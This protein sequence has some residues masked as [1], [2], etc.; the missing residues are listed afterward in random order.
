LSSEPSGDGPQIY[1]YQDSRN[2]QLLVHMDD[3]LVKAITS[4]GE[5]LVRYEYAEKL[6]TKIIYQDNTEKTFHYEN[7]QY[8]YHLT[9]ITNS[10]GVR[11]AT[12]S[13]DSE[14]R[15]ISS[16][17][18]EGV[19]RTDIDYSLSDNQPFPKVSFTNSLGKTTTYHYGNYNG[20]LKVKQVEGQS[21]QNCASANQAYT[22]DSNGFMA[23]KT[24]WKGNVTTYVHNDRGLETSR[25][26]ASGT[27]QARTTTTEWHTAFNLRIKITEPERET[28]LS[29]DENGRLTSQ[30]VNPR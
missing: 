5:E 20:R 30:E 12:W 1:R 10:N 18:A 28:V 25:T 14:G 17:H 15:A 3:E 11:Y 6:L 23:S 24:D 2:N 9:G 22:Y 16:E 7:V 27:P 21:S 4:D 26:E 19:D 13:Y 8:P 29:Y